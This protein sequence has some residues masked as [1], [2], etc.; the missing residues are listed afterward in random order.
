MLDVEDMFAK[1]VT[2]STGHTILKVEN[3]PE[4]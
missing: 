4:P 2:Q 1:L 3:V